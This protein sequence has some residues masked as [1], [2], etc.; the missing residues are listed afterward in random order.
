MSINKSDMSGSGSGSGSG[1]INKSDVSGSGSKSIS[2]TYLYCLPQSLGIQWNLP[3]YSN[4]PQSAW[5]L[6]LY[7]N[8]PQSAWNPPNRRIKQTNFSEICLIGS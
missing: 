6:P 3:L 4:T 2:T 1:L 5:K 8:T 7:S